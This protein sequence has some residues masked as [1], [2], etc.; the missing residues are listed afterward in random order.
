MKN[1][2][3]VSNKPSNCGVYQ[4]GKNIGDALKKSQE[5][6]YIYIEI[7]NNNE[8]TK[9]IA[10]HNPSVI[11]FNYTKDTMPWLKTCLIQ[12]PIIGTIH[13]ITQKIADTAINNQFDFNIAPD[14]TLILKNPLLY[15]TGR[16][17][18][19][20]NITVISNQIP[21]IGSYGLATENKKFLK[22]V[23]IVCAEFENAIIRFNIPPTKYIYES[24]SLINRVV[25]ECNQYVKS[26]PGIKVEFS[27]KY[28]SNQELLQ[29]LAA[30]SLN[31][32]L[33][34]DLWERGISSAL[35]YALS[36]KVPIALSSTTN[37]FRH[38]A[39]TGLEHYVLNNGT[40]LQ[41]IIDKGVDSLEQ[42]YGEWTEENI[43]WDYDRIV[44]DVLARHEGNNNILLN[45]CSKNFYK[46]LKRYIKRLIGK[47]SPSDLNSWSTSVTD[48]KDLQ[49]VEDFGLTYEPVDLPQY[50]KFNS[51]LDDQKR[52][53]FSKSVDVMRNLSLE[54]MKRKVPE[55]V[56]QQGF[57]LD[58]VVRFCNSKKGSS[59]LCVGCFEDTAYSALKSLGY[60]VK[61][62][63]PVLNYDLETF[64]SKPSSKDVSYDL[65]F[66]TSVL[67]HVEDD[68]RF[69]AMMS[70]LLAPGGLI[71]LTCDFREGFEPGDPKPGCD[72]RLYTSSVL[73]K[74]IEKIK[75]LEFI[76]TPEWEKFN[77]DFGSGSIMYS[78]ASIVLRK[79]KV[80]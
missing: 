49:I 71:V 22:I 3:Y 17:R 4:F 33:Y 80:L 10:Q 53:L 51:V 36:V 23:E 14:P 65:I 34:E 39:P 19:E 72:F 27:N 47:G 29:F 15:K 26:H 75:I 1:I 21:I 46:K 52:I 55:A 35:D 48:Y 61:G 32:F 38:V 64:I 28:F 59:I 68:F 74:L 54:T 7:D 73:L 78:F 43:I 37:M 24:N 20:N 76:D 41:T 31:V 62:I 44:S 16:L 42:F 11:I 79:K 18:I 67:E 50:F 57:V 58:T 12:G 70:E 8:L 69:L 13:E 6:N 45:R 56:V 77:P 9:K 40:K 63:D 66:S 5:Y 25:D 2:L 60:N 30:N